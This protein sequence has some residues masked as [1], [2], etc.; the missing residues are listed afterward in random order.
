MTNLRPH[1]LAALRDL[2][3]RW[4][5]RMEEIS[6][7][8]NKGLF[9]HFEE[10][11]AALSSV[12]ELW[13]L[14]CRSGKTRAALTLI[15][16]W[17]DWLKRWNIP[18]PLL[19]DWARPNLVLAPSD[20]V[21]DGAWID[22]WKHVCPPWDIRA[23][24]WDKSR[25]TPDAFPGCI[26]PMKTVAPANTR[27]II[28]SLKPYDTVIMTYHTFRERADIIVSRPYGLFIADECH[29]LKNPA[30]YWTQAAYRVDSV[31]RLGLS[32]TPFTNYVHELIHVLRWL[33]G[34]S[35][36]NHRQSSI[37]PSPWKWESAHC[38]YKY[39]PPK[40]GLA[41]R[42][43]KAGARNPE[44]MYHW[45]CKEVMFSATP[46]E[47]SDAPEPNIRPIPIPLS[48][49]QQ[50]VYDQLARGML[51]WSDANDKTDTFDSG[52]ALA[53]MT[54]LFQLCSD[55]RQLRESICNK[56]ALGGILD[57]TNLTPGFLDGWDLESLNS[58]FKLIEWLASQDEQVLVLT[59]FKHTARLISGD[60][61][62]M[63]YTASYITGDVQ[64]KKR[65]PIITAFKKGEI[66]VMTCTKAA[67][68]GI[69]LAAPHVVLLGFVDHVPGM[70]RQAIRRAWTM[71]DT[72]PVT[73]YDAY[74]P[75]TLEQWN[76]DRL[77]AKDQHATVLT[78]G[79]EPPMFKPVTLEQALKGG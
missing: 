9:A 25:Y 66:Q 21:R 35:A 58:K 61:E 4:R 52:S 55:A 42:K 2:Y 67:W 6:R 57:H 8:Y 37:W 68:Q 24:V 46:A 51:R 65:K 75:N 53:Q 56:R 60:L 62:K 44:H 72:K 31:A 69:S 32:A 18:Q 64:S 70:V 79:K 40:T 71:D 45:L 7:V 12:G 29:M 43:I 34:Y 63:G 14:P 16:H 28:N 47:V 39:I 27:H 19:N 78:G 15:Y 49:K 5:D 30:T 36:H 11:D 23:R 17:Q 59:G 48:M 41:F 77:A 13:D 50:D 38:G 1:Q 73:V 76:R 3:I 74:A 26:W 22:D 33:Q 54:Y 20:M 10:M